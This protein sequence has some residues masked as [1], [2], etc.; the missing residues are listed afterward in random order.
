MELTIPV[1]VWAAILD[2]LNPCAFS[3]LL[4]T[5]AFL[6]STGRTRKE[7]LKIGGAYI[8]AIFAVYVGIGLGVLRALSW[9]GIPHT[10][11]KIGAILL[12]VVGVYQIIQ[13]VFPK[14]PQLG[15]SHKLHGKLAI[16]I[17]KASVPTA[18]VMGALVGLHEFPCTGGP[19]L[20]ILS[21]LHDQATFWSGLGYLL[22]Y[23]LIFVL[24]LGII[25]GVASVPTWHHL[26]EDWKKK[27]MR[28]AKLAVGGLMILLAVVLLLVQAA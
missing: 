15:I 4:L 1:V 19:Y 22:F 21:I 12:L 25:L 6:F 28:M 16:L 13:V 26:V 9:F 5:I 17:S 8:F 11:G 18:L 10:I 14:V 23:N 20:M 3:I 24:P 27:N 7:I 2:S